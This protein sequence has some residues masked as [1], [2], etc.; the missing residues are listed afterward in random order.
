MKSSI[1]VLLIPALLFAGCRL[2]PAYQL[3]C[4]ETPEEWKAAV[5]SPTAASCVDNWWEI[6]EDD[7]LD[8]LEQQALENNPNLSVA[9]EHVFEARAIA[10]VSRADLFPQLNLNPAYSDTGTL[11][12]LYGIPPGL[13][14]FIPGFLQI[15]RVHE[16]QY[17]LPVNL[18]YEV[19]LWGKYRGLYDS[20]V[21]N[22]E[23]V[24]EAYRTSLLTVTSDLAS[25]YFNMRSADAQIEI[26]QRTRELNQNFVKLTRDRFT[27]GLVSNLDVASA[28]LQ[29]SNTEAEYY[30]VVRQRNL[31]ENAIAALVGMPASDL[32]IEAQPL[33]QTPPIIPVGIPSTILEQ[34]PDIAEAERKMASE[35][36]QIGVAYASFFP[37][38]SLTGSLG[39]NSPDLHQFLS[40][41]SRYWEMGATSSQFLFDANR[42]CS[43]LEIAWARFREAEG[44][45]QQVVLTAFQ[46]VE[47]ALTNIE[48]QEKQMASLGRSVQAANLTR[49]L[50]TNRYKSGLVNYLDVIT[51]DQNEL[52]A[53]RN[54]QNILGQRYQ[55][56]I[57]LIKALGGSW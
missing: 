11:F 48:F 20:A 3:A 26:L 13:S 15:L 43:N 7:L 35:H 5:A 49:T 50:S 27:K 41:K 40:W 42:R 25:H 4:V 2:G 28:E 44:S 45:Y 56:T 21:F 6:F 9:L 14:N 52:V 39:Y 33:L 19:D 10:G 31:F 53:R 29:L 32:R 24:V 34:R 16:F 57:Q 12:K 36:A 22:S 8:S 23:A 54:Y 37:S 51:S 38:L 55:S 47:D 17:F 1:F 30:D 46:E 18:S